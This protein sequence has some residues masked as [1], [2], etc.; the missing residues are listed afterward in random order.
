MQCCQLRN[1]ETSACTHLNLF[2]DVL[3]IDCRPLCSL[4]TILALLPRVADANSKL[5][6]VAVECNRGHRR[7]V[8]W[9]LPQPLLGLVVPDRDCAIGPRRREGIVAV[10][11]GLGVY[12]RGHS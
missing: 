12:Q 11:D 2:S 4:G 5:R 9:I 1:Q 7:V 3:D 6:P 8:L 10:D